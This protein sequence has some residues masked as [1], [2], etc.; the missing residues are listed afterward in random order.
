MIKMT[1]DLTNIHQVWI[2][3]SSL[4]NVR[5]DTF[6]CLKIDQTGFYSEL[7]SCQSV[8]NFSLCYYRELFP[9]PS[10]RIMQS[11]MWSDIE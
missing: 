7:S 1:N 2:F 8:Q 6:C 9:T 11:F 4:R 5:N 10:S 3:D